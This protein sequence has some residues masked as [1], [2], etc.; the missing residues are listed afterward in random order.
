LNRKNEIIHEKADDFPIAIRFYEEGK[1]PAAEK[2]LKDILR[3]NPYDTDA[4][5]FLGGIYLSE[6]SFDNAETCYK[7]ILS[8]AEDHPTANYNIAFVLHKLNRLKEAEE[9]YKKT[10]L[11][12]PNHIDALH[13]LGDLFNSL[14]RHEEA[15]NYYSEVI[16]LNSGRSKTLINIANL[17]SARG[18]YYKAEYYYSQAIFFDP[19]NSNYAISLSECYLKLNKYDKAINNLEVIIK[20]QP[21]CDEAVKML[22]EIVVLKE[23]SE[24][25]SNN[26]K[27]D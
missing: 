8:L 27:K 2:T 21:D 25:Q 22:K 1:I 10:L 16:K 26:F 9:Y 18:E 23:E 15:L 12:N 17:L 5:L 19:L 24:K 14:G 4:L 13:N 6:G 3:K 20:E 11:I 7:K